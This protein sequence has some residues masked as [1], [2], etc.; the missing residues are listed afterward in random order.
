MDERVELAE[1]IAR[2][3]WVRAPLLPGASNPGPADLSSDRSFEALAE[4]VAPFRI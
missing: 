3:I 2:T 1:R 4:E